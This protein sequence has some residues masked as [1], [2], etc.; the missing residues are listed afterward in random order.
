MTQSAVSCHVTQLLPNFLVEQGTLLMLTILRAMVDSIT[1]NFLLI[2]YLQLPFAHTTHVYGE[3]GLH[4]LVMRELRGSLGHF[5]FVFMK[6]WFGYQVP[7]ILLPWSWAPTLLYNLSF[8]IFQCPRKGKCTV[9]FSFLR[10][11]LIRLLNCFRSLRK[12]L[13]VWIRYN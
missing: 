12:P 3:L 9:R 4:V 13:F 1:F 5:C 2:L 8:H 6:D 11:C 7:T 10:C